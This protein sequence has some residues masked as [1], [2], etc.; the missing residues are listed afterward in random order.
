MEINDYRAQRRQI[1]EMEHHAKGEASV[2][3]DQ[4]S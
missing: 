3:E 4:R 1:D 2:R